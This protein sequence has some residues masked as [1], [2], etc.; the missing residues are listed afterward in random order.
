[1]IY[2]EET[3]VLPRTKYTRVCC[4]FVLYI[5]QAILF[6]SMRTEWTTG[7]HRSNDGLRKSNSRKRDGSC[8]RVFLLEG[9]LVISVLQTQECPARRTIRDDAYAHHQNSIYTQLAWFMITSGTK[10]SSTTL[11]MNPWC[12]N[13]PKDTTAILHQSLSGE[14]MRTCRTS[15]I[16][17]TPTGL[18]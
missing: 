9:G 1:V 6:H 4:I 16:P 7:A 13:V 18:K 15:H 14:I 8:C 12:N 2:L 11:L 17:L 10:F 5:R 3:L